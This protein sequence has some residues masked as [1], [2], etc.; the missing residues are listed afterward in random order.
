MAELYTGL[1][2]SGNVTEPEMVSRGSEAE[3]LLFLEEVKQTPK[4]KG[5]GEGA[6]GWGSFS[7]PFPLFLLTSFSC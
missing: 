6:Q 3:T 5:K 2:Q 1:R 4:V 7:L